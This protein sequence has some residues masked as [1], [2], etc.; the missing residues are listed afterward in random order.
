MW[1]FSSHC[2]QT[3]HKLIISTQ[4]WI[5]ISNKNVL[6]LWYNAN[7]ITTDEVSEWQVYHSRHICTSSLRRT[8]SWLRLEITIRWRCQGRHV[9]SGNW[10]L[11]CCDPSIGSW[12]VLNVQ[13]GRG[14]TTPLSKTKQQGTQCAYKD[15][16]ATKL[17][18]TR[19]F[20][21]GYYNCWS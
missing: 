18:L 1:C 10:R 13:S 14:F 4:T 5:C 7:K 9:S 2:F 17:H 12:T 3:L 20:F 8:H 19:P 21:S 6:F 16:P 15:V 11:V